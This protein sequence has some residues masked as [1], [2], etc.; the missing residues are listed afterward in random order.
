VRATALW[1]PVAA[2]T[3]GTKTHKWLA[4]NAEQGAT[5]LLAVQALDVLWMAAMWLGTTL[6]LHRRTRWAATVAAVIAHVV[7]GVWGL[8]V[9]AE[10]GYF[11]GTGAVGDGYMVWELL[12]RW[13]E[14][15]AV[16]ASELTA[17]RIAGVAAPLSYAWVLLPLL[18]W[19]RGPRTSWPSATRAEWRQTPFR[20]WLAAMAVP[21]VVAAAFLGVEPHDSTAFLGRNAIVSGVSELA[22]VMWEE[23]DDSSVFGAVEPLDPIILTRTKARARNALVITLESVSAKG[24]SL[25]DPAPYGASART[26][27]FLESLAKK[28]AL[29]D[30]AYTVMPHTSKA[31]VAIHCG[32]YPKFVPKV[33]EAEPGAI[34]SECLPRLLREQGFATAF[35]QPAEENYEKRSKLVAEFGFEKFVGK[36]SIRGAGFDES[37]YFGWEDDA[38]LEPVVSWI[39]GQVKRGKPFFAGVLTL[40]A[41]HPYSVPKGYVTKKYVSDRTINDYLNTVAYT[42]RFVEKL[43]GELDRIGALED[44][45][46]VVSG[47]H[48]EAFGEHGRYQHDTAVYEENI[49]IPMVLAG[50]GVGPG[51]NIE[52]LRQL[53]DVMPTVLSHLGFAPSRPLPGKSLLSEPGHEQLYVHCYFRGYCRA[54]LEGKRKTIDNFTRKRPEI[55]DLS[56]DPLERNNLFGQQDDL[57]EEAKRKVAE[58]ASIVGRSNAQYAAQSE[59]RLRAFVTMTKP[60]IGTP[61]EIDFGPVQIVAYSVTPNQIEPGGQVDITVVYHVE[62]SPPSGLLTFTHLVRGDGWSNADHVPVG[63]AY[64]VS[65]WQPGEYIVDHFTI[66]TRPDTLKGKHTVATGFWFEKEGNLAPLKS[67]VHVDEKTR[68]HLGSYQVTGRNVDLAKHVLRERPSV[69]QPIEVHFGDYLTL[70]SAGLDRAELKGGLKVGADYIFAVHRQLPPDAILKA[71]VRGPSSYTAEY[72]PVQGHY[73]LQKWQAGEFISDK[74]EII[75]KTK[76]QPGT[77]TVELSLYVGARVI[78][79]SGQGRAISADGAVEVGSYRLVTSVRGH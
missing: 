21:S 75:T 11:L 16:V 18:L 47:D 69:E 65:E 32:M 48:G 35:F 9:G 3:L 55:Y 78:P 13:S 33:A 10:H 26:T 23:G 28:G 6:L 37:S 79:A 58:M 51:A 57:D 76:D 63:G 4:M 34:P 74:Q 41:H 50:P 8:L 12:T 7:A 39:E 56:A 67:S 54:I 36:E 29:V 5:D 15:N 30:T 27:P 71:R 72:D 31:L 20:W 70:H 62:E 38:L 46:V 17:V 19:R 45:L 24:T 53:I 59:K 68:V 22:L 14:V 60:E 77:Y 73:P 44:T 1:A 61:V 49:R 40:T 42:D 43:L 52:G 25:Y 66:S 64:P 2:L